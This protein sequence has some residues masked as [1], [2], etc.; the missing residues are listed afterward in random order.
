MSV[1]PGQSCSISCISYIASMQS[2]KSM[3]LYPVSSTS[4]LLHGG[5]REYG[6]GSSASLTR[7][8]ADAA[9]TDDRSPT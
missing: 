3:G 4:S 8:I 7:K 1:Q 5:A 6:G 2:A 9:T